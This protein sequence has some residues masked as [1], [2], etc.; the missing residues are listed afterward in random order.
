MSGYGYDIIIS[1]GGGSITVEEVDGVPSVPNVNTIKFAN[2][3][4]FTVTN[5]GGGVVR[6]NVSAAAAP[7]NDARILAWLLGGA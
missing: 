6:I 5:E 1:T 7:D 2:A 4:G 3:D